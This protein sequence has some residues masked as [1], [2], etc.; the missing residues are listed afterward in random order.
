MYRTL[1]TPR[2]ARGL[3]TH[4]LEWM[5]QAREHPEWYNAVTSNCATNT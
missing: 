5:S 3:F 2:D 4:Y 1:T